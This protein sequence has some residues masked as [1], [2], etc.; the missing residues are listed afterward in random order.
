VA[1]GCIH[2]AWAL[3]LADGTRLF[4]KTGQAAVLPCLEREREG[5]EAL[6]TASAGELVV[7]RPLHCG[8]SGGQAVLVMA[9]LDLDDGRGHPGVDRDQAWERAGVALARLHRRSA[10][11]GG[12][13]FG[14]HCD[15]FIG[16]NIQRNGWSRDWGQFF[17]QQRL[18]VQLGLAAAAGRRLRGH[19]DL[20]DRTP[21]WLNAHGA[22]P[23]LVHGDLWAGNAALLPR[24]GSAPGPMAAALF[25]P[26]VHRA[27]REVD[28]AMA[29]LFGGFPQAFFSGYDLEWPRPPGH[30]RRRRLYDLYHLL[31]HANL[32]GGGYWQQAQGVIDQLLA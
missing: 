28:L 23:C 18:G 14:W 24:E 3:R 6:A 15:N 10:E 4:A 32:F 30:P 8:L 13:G 31:N 27:D 26:A 22:L 12:E 21:H 11:T 20:L 29:Q 16:T 17:A 1:G 25:D 7:P 5:L 19:Q 2:S 9:W